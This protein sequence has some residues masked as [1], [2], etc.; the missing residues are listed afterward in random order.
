MF[1]APTAIRAI[2][3][4][5]PDGDF[6]K[7]YDLSCLRN[8]FLAGERCDSA[9]IEW[10]QKHIPIPVIDHWW[11]TESGWPMVANSLGL[12][13]M[14]VKLGSA[15]KPVCGYDLKIFSEDG[16]E[17]G[18]NQEGLVVL[19]LPLPPGNMLGLWGN[20]TRFQ[21]GYFK[22]FEGY[23]LSGDGGYVDEDGYVFI[24]GRVDD[25][26]NVAG[27]RLSTA[28]M[29]EIV[30]SHSA[31]AECAVIGIQD[32][33]KGQIPVALAVVKVG[34]AMERFQLEYEIVQLVRNQIGAVA[35]LRN[36]IIVERLPKTRSGK[37]LR[38]L[39][40]SIADGLE[41]Q[42]PSTIDDESI[43]AEIEL[44]FYNA[45]INNLI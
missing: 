27:H 8:Q 26:I 34:N 45:K 20:I 19:K 38:K 1:T 39:L 7:K 14:A 17:L 13:K 15:T 23:Y 18:A 41:F 3:K 28:E 33:L 35:S 37:T 44:A 10:F 11:Q 4:E 24:T 2:K 9:T 16:K 25:V 22:K 29:E 12:E 40:R 21:E 36:V 31:V 42:I 43:I 6:I 32:E 30:S 5:D